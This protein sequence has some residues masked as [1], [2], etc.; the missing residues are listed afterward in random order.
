MHYLAFLAV[1]FHAFICVAGDGITPT[2]PGPG[3]KFNAGSTCTIQWEVGEN[4]PNFTISLMSGSNTQ[5]QLV[6]TIANGLDGSDTTLSPYNWTCPEVNPYSAIYFYQFTNGNDTTNSKWTT[7]FTVN[8]STSLCTAFVYSLKHISSFQIASPSGD[9][10]SPVNSTQPNGDAIPWGVGSLSA[11]MNT[12][13]SQESN[14]AASAATMTAALSSTTSISSTFSDLPASSSRMRKARMSA[15][16]IERQATPTINIP[17]GTTTPGASTAA[18]TF[19][20]YRSNA[21]SGNGAQGWNQ[22]FRAWSFLVFVLV[23]IGSN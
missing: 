20:A 12:T 6:T 15:T 21:Q 8:T 18:T 11:S 19:A 22:S 23:L 5:M 2:A 13:Q 7:R 3:D 14:S 1:L 4:W 17:S 10:S 16:S 9:F